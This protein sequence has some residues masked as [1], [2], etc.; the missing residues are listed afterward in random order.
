[1]YHITQ[2]AHCITSINRNRRV[3]FLRTITL[4]E[5]NSETTLSWYLPPAVCGMWAHKVTKGLPE[6]FAEKTFEV[7]TRFKRN[8]VRPLSSV[9]KSIWQ[10]NAILMARPKWLNSIQYCIFVVKI[11]MIPVWK[12]KRK[13]HTRV[14]VLIIILSIVLSWWN[15]QDLLAT[16]RRRSLVNIRW[17]CWNSFLCNWFNWITVVKWLSN[18]RFREN[19]A[20]T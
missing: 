18:I 9:E 7:F 12:F 3:R 6:N 13:F 20:C 14:F 16:S 11:L 15:S 5:K 17:I 8:S 4:S 1:M 2:Y 19:F 10:F